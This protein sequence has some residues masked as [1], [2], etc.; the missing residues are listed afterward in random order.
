M[1]FSLEMSAKMTYDISNHMM[2]LSFLGAANK[3]SFEV[4]GALVEAFQKFN[5]PTELS[6][7]IT[8]DL[9]QD[10]INSSYAEETESL[11]YYE[12]KEM[13]KEI[14]MMALNM[15]MY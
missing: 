10:C 9:M 7:I 6:I 1:R 11:W 15:G 14:D 8:G 4:N 5:L 13:R 3:V 2:A 12:V